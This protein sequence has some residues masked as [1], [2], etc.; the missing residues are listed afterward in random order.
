MKFTT[1]AALAAI[2]VCA[3]QTFA[4]CQQG[5]QPGQTGPKASCDSVAA[6]HWKCAKYGAE[7]TQPSNAPD[8]INFNAGRYPVTFEFSCLDDPTNKLTVYCPANAAGKFQFDCMSDGRTA[9]YYVN[10]PPKN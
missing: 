9:K 1:S 3:G 4:Q 10:A 6:G 5:V 8:F 2:A 7:I